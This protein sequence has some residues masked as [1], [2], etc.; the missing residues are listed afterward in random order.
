MT[1]PLHGTILHGFGACTCRPA[2][3][4]EAFGRDNEDWLDSRGPGRE[5]MRHRQE[6]RDRIVAEYKAEIEVLRRQRSD[7]FRR[8]NHLKF[9]LEH[10]YGEGGDGA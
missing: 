9:L 3:G 10:T 4:T 2:Q 1:C 6:H 8:I 7:S 5:A